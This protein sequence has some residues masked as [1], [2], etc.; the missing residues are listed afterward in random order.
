M[1]LPGSLALA[2]TDSCPA[3]V[4]WTHVVPPAMNTAAEPPTCVI[5]P[6]ET[7]G[8]LVSTTQIA[9]ADFDLPPA[10]AFTTKVCLPAATF[11]MVPAA[12]HFLT[13][14]LSS[15]QVMTAVFGDAL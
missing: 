4:G 7:T 1:P 12:L 8:G 5:A 11:T 6:T 14:F 3:V 10:V 9:V 15:V 2:G 13:F